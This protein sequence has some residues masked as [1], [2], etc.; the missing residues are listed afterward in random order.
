M[1]DHVILNE[2]KSHPVSVVLL[3]YN[4]ANTIANEIL[5]IHNEIISKIPGSEIIVGE[6]GSTDGTSSILNGLENSGLIV[7][8]T[9]KS[10]K[11]YKKALEDALRISK[12]DLIFFSDTGNKYDLK[13]FWKL[14]QERS[15]YDLIV[16]HKYPRHD[17]YY[18]RILTYSYN[19]FIRFIFQISNIRDSDSGFRLFNSNV[20][21]GIYLSNLNFFTSLYN[22]EIVIRAVKGGLKYTE[23]PISYFQREGVS[24]GIPPRKIFSVI[25]SSLINLIKLKLEVNRIK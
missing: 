22:S 13:D 7:H 8:S 10:R 19:A 20:K 3:A 11:G 12:N 23:V 18:R 9:S 21:F 5:N 16:G 1:N 14:Y 24:R 2:S 15:S 17:Q 25:I 6:D 4:E